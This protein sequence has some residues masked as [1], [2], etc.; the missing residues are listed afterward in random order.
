MGTF[1]TLGAGECG[2]KVDAIGPHF[3]KE[4]SSDGHYKLHFKMLAFQELVLSLEV[5]DGCTPLDFLRSMKILLSKPGPMDGEMGS[6]VPFDKQGVDLL[7]E[8][9]HLSWI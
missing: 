8:D 5:Y 4:C 9:L 7:P 1:W 2:N 3:W 6:E